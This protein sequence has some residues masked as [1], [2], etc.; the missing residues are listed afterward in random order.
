[1]VF[2]SHLLKLCHVLKS[3]IYIPACSLCHHNAADDKADKRYDK[4]I[5]ED[6]LQRSGL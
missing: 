5:G 4:H 3:E 2:L 1:M 6:C